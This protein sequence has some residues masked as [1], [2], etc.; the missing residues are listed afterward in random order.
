MQSQSAECAVGEREFYFWRRNG[1]GIEFPPAIGI[2]G[3]HAIFNPFEP[4]PHSLLHAFASSVPQRVREQLFHRQI[5][6]ELDFTIQ[7]VLL[8]KPGNFFGH[9]PQFLKVAIESK[10]HAAQIRR[11]WHT[12]AASFNARLLCQHEAMR[13]VVLLAVAA[14][15]LPAQSSEDAGKAVRRALP[16]LERSA[17]EFVSKRNCVSCHHNILPILM[18]HMARERGIEIDESVLTAVEGKT[19]RALRSPTALDDAI[20]AVT[21][22][23]PTPNDSFLLMAAG[24]AGI[25]RSLVAAV[26]ARRLL[27][28]Q[29]DG[30]WVTS[31]FRPPHSSSVFTATATA[32]RAISLYLP[33]EM[34]AE[35]EA[36]LGRARRWLLATAPESV[37]DASFRVLGL[38]WAGASASE[39]DT[40]AKDLLAFQLPGGGWPELRGYP[41]DAYSTG[42]ALFALHQAGYAA[43]A[44]SWRKGMRFL[45]STQAG[46]GSWR[47]RTRMVSP[48]QVSPP[49]F[50]TGFPYGKDEYISYAGSCWA[51]M[52]LLS[53][54]PERSREPQKTDRAEEPAWIRSALFGTTQQ[55]STGDPNSRTANGTTVLMMAVPDAEKV[56]LLLKR[57]ADVKARAPSGTD[58]LTIAA[59]YRGSAEA[60][61]LLLGAGAEM[62]P[63]AGGHARNTPLQF[64]ALSGDLENI[65][66]LLGHG[67]DPSAAALASAVT[68]GYVDVVQTLIAAGAPARGTEASGINLLHWAVI[69]NRPA[70]IPTLIAAGVPLNATDENGYTPLMYAASIDFGDTRSLKALLRGGADAAIRN[71]EGRT[72]REQARHF[73]HVALEAALR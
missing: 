58:A 65:K 17:G 46:D 1:R 62:K 51:V 56:R 16:V 29:R 44:Q 59:A 5:Q 49:Y 8:A 18:L 42:E 37:E 2:L 32:V 45:I 67:A 3:L 57:G 43:G 31:D 64:A 20:Q 38:V 61:R 70:V 10:F 11:L 54:V 14:Q 12:D 63:S 68:F 9:P 36:C 47:I 71:N 6:V 53:A 27:G 4:D 25:E 34:G 26:Y 69:A 22:N 13:S 73:G 23:D 35:R 21:L 28:W 48:A 7:I 30:H 40:A 41:A 52:A 19:F 33:E 66:L 60:L 15:C 72:A 39:I 50:A 55:L 24:A